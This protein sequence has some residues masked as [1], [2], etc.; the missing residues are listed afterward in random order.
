MN[1]ASAR[2]FVVDEGCA[3]VDLSAGAEQKSR[4]NVFGQDHLA[5]PRFRE[6]FTQTFAR[7]LQENFRNPEAVAVSFDVRYQTAV[8]WWNAEHRASG[9]TVALVFMNFPSAVAW[10]LAEWEGHE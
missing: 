8:N 4:S 3:R 5:D 1:A 6:W 9:D 10:F 7:F 2:S